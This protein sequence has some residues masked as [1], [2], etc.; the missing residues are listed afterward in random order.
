LCAIRGDKLVSV[1]TIGKALRAGT[2]CG[3]YS[4]FN[5]VDEG[6]GGRAK[7]M[8]LRAGMP[9]AAL[10]GKEAW[11]ANLF[12]SDVL[13][14]LHNVDRA[15]FPDT[16]LRERAE[17]KGKSV[18]SPWR[19]VREALEYSA[20]LPEPVQVLMLGKTLDDSDTYSK[21]VDAWLRAEIDTLSTMANEA[22]AAHPDIHREI[23]AQQNVEWVERIRQMLANDQVE[24]VSLDIGHLVGPDNV[25]TQLEAGGAQ[26]QR[27]R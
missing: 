16:V 27:S 11:A 8:L 3:C 12:L 14:R 19:D 18:H 7:A 24:F 5:V 6:T 20:G 23:N 4:I 9:A 26:V 2:K 25:L 10:E 13:R 15:S 17:A 21:R 22:A 1:E